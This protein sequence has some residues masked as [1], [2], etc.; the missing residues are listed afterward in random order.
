[1]ALLIVVSIV[2]YGGIAWWL[3]KQNPDLVKILAILAVWGFLWWL[4]IPIGENISGNL[5]GFWAVCVIGAFIWWLSG[6]GG[7]TPDGGMD[8]SNY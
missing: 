5:A 7:N 3:Y 2:F 4:T 8:G 1:M 6:G